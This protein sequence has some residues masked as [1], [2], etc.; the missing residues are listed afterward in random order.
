MGEG[1][2]PRRALSV[3]PAHVALRPTPA[4]HAQAALKH[5]AVL[6]AAKHLHRRGAP[7]TTGTL[8]F[9][10]VLQASHQKLSSWR[11]RGTPSPLRHF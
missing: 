1:G 7:S 11:D 9:T 3:Q 10:P 6:A 4:T 5:A 8:V 2:F